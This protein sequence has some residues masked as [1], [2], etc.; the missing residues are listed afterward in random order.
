[1]RYILKICIIFVISLLLIFSLAA[2][3]RNITPDDSGSSENASVSSII[4]G[5]TDNSNDDDTHLDI[6]DIFGSSSSLSNDSSASSSSLSSSSDTSD[7]SSSSN[8]SDTTGSNSSTTSSGI[9][10]DDPNV[11]TDPM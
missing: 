3:K 2:C 10:Y 7:T 11:W 4:T 1:M 8:S 6:N 5:S 9:N